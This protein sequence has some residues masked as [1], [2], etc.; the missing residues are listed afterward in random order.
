MNIIIDVILLAIIVVSAVFAA[1][2]G[3]IGTLFSLAGT[4]VA[5][6]LAIM[7]S[8]PVSGFVDA[9]FINPSVKKYILTVVDSSAAGKSYNAALESIDVAQKI[10]EMPAPLK[11]VL[12]LAGIDSQEVVNKVS[13]VSSN[14]AEAKDAY[15]KM[16]ADP[17][18]ATIS[19]VLT[20]IGLFIVLFIILW[21]VTK[22]LEAV[23]N[24]IPFGE[25]ANRAGGLIFGILRG[26]V[27]VLAISTLFTALSKGVDPDSNNIFSQKT[28]DSTVLLKTVNDFNP[29]NSF[30]NIK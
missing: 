20:L 24:A 30:L 13:A 11:A 9:Q 21:V 12:D 6:I 16:I 17:I 4:V 28:I 14:V 5:V 7:L 26:V 29:I 27:I 10:K 3:F 19:R 2:R 25:G 1:K 23:F 18:S 22:L 8:G 15:I